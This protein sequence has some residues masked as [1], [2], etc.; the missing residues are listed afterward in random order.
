MNASKKSHNRSKYTFELSQVITKA[1]E[2]GSSLENASKCA[3]ISRPMIYTRKKKYKGLA[4]RLEEAL[5]RQELNLVSYIYSVLSKQ[6]MTLVD[7]MKKVY[8]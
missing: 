1:V 2:E 3:E 7:R 5:S 4:K 8:K 6:K